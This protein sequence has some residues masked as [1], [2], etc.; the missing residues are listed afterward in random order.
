[1]AANHFRMSTYT[2]T[3][4]VS[5]DEREEVIPSVDFAAL[6][7]ERLNDATIGG[8]IKLSYLADPVN[9]N[10]GYGYK[11]E[12]RREDLADSVIRSRIEE[13]ARNW[14]AAHFKDHE[15]SEAVTLIMDI[16][17]KRAARKEAVL[18]G[19]QGGTADKFA[20]VLN[21]DWEPEA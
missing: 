6:T 18:S 7:I 20:E 8:E 3:L 16:L 1:M 11:L 19:I 15:V 12:F 14:A 4:K 9:G 5:A 13:G 10:T 21:P 2:S 17:D